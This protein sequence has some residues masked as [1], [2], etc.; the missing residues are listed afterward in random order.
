MDLR[1]VKKLIELL[2]ESGIAEIEIKEGEE[3]VRISRMMPTMQP[4]AAQMMAPVSAAIPLVSAPP[5]VAKPDGQVITSPMVGTYYASPSVDSP[6]F[7]KIGQTVKVG[8]PLC[9]IE[10][11]KIMNPIEADRAGTVLSI[12]AENGQPVEFEQPL[13][14]IS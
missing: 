9:I 13:F 7:V 12:M 3:S 4:F 5:A 2:E 1:K 14:I 6:P 8:E 11:M 10:A